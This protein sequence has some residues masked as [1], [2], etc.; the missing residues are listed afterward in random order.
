MKKNV[1]VVFFALLFAP[2]YSHAQ[3]L[4]SI[5]GKVTDPAGAGVAGAQ[6]TA[7]QEATGFSR[8]ATSDSDGFYVIPSLQPAVY[9]LT[10]EAKGFNTSKQHGITL[11]ADQSLTVNADLKLGSVTEVVN[12][13][14]NAVQVDTST[15][16]LRQVVEGQ[17]ISELPLNGRNA[18]QLTLTVA[19]AVNAPNGGADQ[20]ATKTFPGAVTYSTNGTRQDTISY[21]LDGGNYVDE[22]TNVNQ[23]FPFPDALQ[24]FSVQ[25]SNYSAQYGE[26]AGG[27]VNVI[28]KSGS[29]NFHGDGF[30]FVRN[31]YFNAQNYFAT[32]T[33]HDQI[34]RNQFGGTLGGPII[35]DKTFFFVGY[36]RT[37]FR[38]LVLGSSHVVGQTDI[39]N[40]LA[41]GGP[42][43]TPGTID[44]GV[45]KML[46]ID[47]TTGA[48][49]GSSAK[50]S[51]AGPI[52]A[53]SS[54]TVA[55]SKPDIENYDSGMGR[56]DHSIGK[57]D[58]LTGRYE[59]DRFTKAGVFNPL[60]LVAYTDAT[61]SIT[62]QNALLHETH[63]F[64]PVVINDF[65]MSYS[66]EV[67]SR[68][69]APGAVDLSTF[70]TSPLPF[71]PTPSA[72]QGI[73]VQSGFSFGDNPTGIFTRNNFAYADD[74][75]WEKGKH[76]IH[77]GGAIEWSQMD[78]NNQFNQPGIVNFCTQDTYDINGYPNGEPAGLPTYQNFLAGTMCDGNATGNGYAFQ[79][80]AGEYKANRDKFPALYIQD[81]YRVNGRLTLNLGLRYEP[82][83]PWSD[84]GDRWAQVN[85]TA[86]AADI[87]SRVYPN[88]PPGIFFSSANGI[89]S[90]PGMPKNA[91]N[92]SLNGFAPRIG[93][94]YD[95]FGD[96]KT[97]LRGGFGI[98]YDTRAEG[99]LSNRFVDEWPFSPQ[100]I[101]STAGN[102]SP[103]PGSTAGSFSDPLC[104]EPATQ[105]A[106]NCSGAQ[107]T[108]YPTF[109]SPFPAPTNFA[110]NPPFNE[111]AVTYD[112]SGVYHVPTVYEWN[113]T[114]ERE[115]PAGILVRAA[116]VG[117]RSTH[118]LE[119]QYY[120]AGV[121][122]TDPTSAVMCNGKANVGIANLTVCEATGGTVASCNGN[123][124][125]SGALFKPN[126]F[127]TTVQADINDI[128]ANYHSLQMTA[129][130]RMNHGLTI[131]ANYTYSKS[132]DDL[133]FG[134]GV[135][136]FD[137]G[138]ST[139][140]L[141][142]PDRHAFDYGPS[143]F[144]HTHVFSGSY[145]WHSP[146]L[147][148]HSS[149]ISHLFGDYELS[150]IVTAASGRPIT[151][152]QGTELSG[153]GIGNDRG[154][155][156]AGVDPYSSTAC[157][158]TTNCVSWL[159]PAAFQHTKVTSGCTP[160]ATSCNNSVIFGTFGNIGKNV[161]RLP[162]SADWDIAVS[163]NILITE[164][165]K[166]QLRAEYFNILN[167]PNFAPESISTG[168]V[169]S[170][171][172]ISNFDKLSSSS[173]GTFRAGEAGDP[174]IAQFALKF[175]F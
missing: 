144:D 138:Y 35:R 104:V 19:G 88:A 18:A 10:V 55:Y 113:L 46:G 48:Y 172:Q 12:V 93:F 162:H 119:T 3:G 117:T 32:P 7:T 105:L 128:N 97:S 77:F 85:L 132:L 156:I 56:F 53:G 137:T 114:L 103:T 133:P 167:H 115:L 1:L 121:P 73:G 60:E 108:S 149:L 107:A 173:F 175:F 135:T 82:A 30:E 164:R 159:N 151:V 14:A 134:E 75:S 100:F 129:Q 89:S 174:R 69:P 52:P 39:A 123:A 83:L 160:P 166:L 43:G 33:T 9:S 110:Y 8:S 15:S 120:N 76:D 84:N 72:I 68:G 161:L 74:V 31:P 49:L 157:G 27:V 147:S 2:L 57:K 148:E 169:N 71:E 116:Y 111:I 126:T 124:N 143:S 79:Q 44:P 23:P 64:S 155:F 95:V 37:T 28:T 152:L 86:M 87:T 13:T 131:L 150:G 80:G 130:K 91:L 24:E 67:S 5:L 109:P 78:L 17:R 11:L 165:W 4:G 50:F 101:L 92:S 29:N 140:P 59:F 153:T 163:K 142:N 127:S 146:S 62:A 36:Q 61:H 16:T 51:L 6:V 38:N 102:S 81:N 66:R 41:S 22:Y 54:P 45:A 34:K 154:T 70:E 145:V 42:G 94:A 168:T 26:N 58:K 125:R 25:T 136:G 40:F 96:G 20:G 170:T 141:D 65:R 21:Q 118:I 47:P 171:D 63:I 98:F 106:L 139:L 158:T 112:P 99:M 122:C 90:D